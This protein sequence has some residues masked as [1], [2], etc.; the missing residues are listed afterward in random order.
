MTWDLTT[1]T[2][3]VLVSHDLLESVATGAVFMGFS[4]KTDLL[5]F[6]YDISSVWRH[7]FTARYVVFDS[8]T[9]KRYDV[10]AKDG[11]KTLQYCNWV[12][13]DRDE[14]ILIYVS[15][16]NLYWRSANPVAE[17]DKDIAVT[18]DGETDNVF[19][20]IP[21][22]VYEEEVLGVNYAH[23][24]NDNA[25]LV[26]FAQFNDSLVKDFRYPFYGD[27]NVSAQRSIIFVSCINICSYRMSLVTSIQS[28]RS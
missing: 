7:S 9:Q 18:T 12:D 21:D 19:N 4:Q 13:N 23:Y 25:D 28:I 5:L 10:L 27:Q 20:G 3:D 24:I 14:N 26:A 11:S 16:N 1:N 22:W 8:N 15:N 6:A 17:A 2:T